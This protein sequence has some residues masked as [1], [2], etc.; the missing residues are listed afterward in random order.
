M[1]GKFISL[2]SNFSCLCWVKNRTFRWEQDENRILVWLNS[3]LYWIFHHFF[4]YRY[5]FYYLLLYLFKK[6]C[7]SQV[8]II[9]SHRVIYFQLTS[10]R[11]HHLVV[12][13]EVLVIITTEDRYLNNVS[14]EVE[15]WD[16]DFIQ[17]INSVIVFM[18]S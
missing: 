3:H 7:L 12:F 14:V 10:K 5:V 17:M 15:S 11:A 2:L 13:V 6:L 9:K 1:D 8:Y 18:K 4:S 16:D